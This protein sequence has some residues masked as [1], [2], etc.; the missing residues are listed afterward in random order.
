MKAVS[1][2]IENIN[3][4]VEIIKRS[5]T[6]IFGAEKYNKWHEKLTRKVW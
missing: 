4:K 6:D 5:H 2:Q 1:Q 3:K